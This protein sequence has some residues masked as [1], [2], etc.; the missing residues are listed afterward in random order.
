[1]IEF[2]DNGHTRIRYSVKDNRIRQVNGEYIYVINAI[3]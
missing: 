2:A 3:V 1:M